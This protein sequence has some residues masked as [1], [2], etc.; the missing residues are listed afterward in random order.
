V[1]FSWDCLQTWGY[2]VLLDLVAL[3][4]MHSTKAAIDSACCPWDWVYKSVC[5]LS[6][7]FSLSLSH[8]VEGRMILNGWRGAMYCNLHCK[9]F[10]FF[11]CNVFANWKSCCLLSNM[12]FFSL[13]ICRT[14]SD[15]DVGICQ[16]QAAVLELGAPISGRFFQ[17]LLKSS[18]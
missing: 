14:C 17:T 4:H 12:G 7:S 5:V 16:F 15:T 11:S 3:W 13:I 1:V 6:L 18:V 8:L 10:P 2:L 9:A